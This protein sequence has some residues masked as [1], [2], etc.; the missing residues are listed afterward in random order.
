MPAKRGGAARLLWYSGVLSA[1]AVVLAVLIWQA[2]TAAGNPDPT[3]GDVSPG[4][5]IMDTA[6][7][8]FRDAAV[9]KA[10][11]LLENARKRGGIS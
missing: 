4:A 3:V 5:A 7:L 1:L 10:R 2:V 8:V 9:E 6:V 11:R